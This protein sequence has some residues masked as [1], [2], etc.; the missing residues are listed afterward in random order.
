MKSL[1]RRRER[2][3]RV[4]R[5]QHLQAAAVAAEAEGRAIQLESTSDKLRALRYSLIPSPGQTFGSAL[6]S[7]SELGERLERVRDGLTDAIVSA[8]A[9]AAQQAALRLAARI[10]EESA[11]RLKEKSEIAWNTDRERRMS[12]A[13]AGRRTEGPLS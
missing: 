10:R 7:V 9:H 6:S 3:V 1:I 2:I 12:A 11:L 13:R 5:V 4:R 8:R